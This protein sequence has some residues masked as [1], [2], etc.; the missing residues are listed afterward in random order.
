MDYR[1]PLYLQIREA[2]KKKIEEKEYLT[3][4]V[5]PSERKL[6]EMYGV[7]RMTVKYAI[8]SLVAEGYLY[9]VQGKGTFVQKE[10][11]QKIIWSNDS[12]G[13][14]AMLREK[15]TSRKDKVVVKGLI[16]AFNFL[17]SKLS[18][19]KYEDV[20]VLQRIRYVNE[21]PFA[22]EYCY[23]PFK[24]FKD[25][26]DHNFENTS[27]YE[28]MKSKNHFPVDFD[29]KL[30]IIESDGRISKLL[31]VPDGTPTYYFEFISR[32]QYG[33]VVE[34]T[35]TYVNCEK[36]VFNFNFDKNSKKQ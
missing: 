23:V 22:V 35:E 12:Q 28:Y 14:G 32:D 21:E 15:G 24:F 18:L 7:N 17:G 9:K 36:A 30:I 20:Y 10:N 6:A 2:L 26:D 27:V 19:A 31:G 13:L 33:N 3:G 4:E 8:D 1:M 34:Y 25:I 16:K 11:S 5:I 29:Q